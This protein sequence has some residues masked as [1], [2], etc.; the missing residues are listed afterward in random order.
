MIDRDPTPPAERKQIDG[1]WVVAAMLLGYFALV[2]VMAHFVGYKKAW[3]HVGVPG[4]QPVFADLRVITAAAD[5]DRDGYN[6]LVESPRDHWKRPMDY[7]RVWLLPLQAFNLGQ[8]ATAALGFALAAAF[9]ACV[10]WFMGRVSV[11]QGVLWGLLL[12]APSTM[13]AVERGNN[14]LV[15]F[16]LLALAVIFLRRKE[17]SAWVAYGLVGLCAVLK[18]YPICAFMLAWRETPRRTLT[19]FA[20]AALL[21]GGYLYGIRADLHTLR[22][23][24]PRARGVAYGARV[25]FDFIARHEEPMGTSSPMPVVAALAAISLAVLARLRI[26]GPAPLSRTE[27]DGLMVG[28]ALYVS[29]FVVNSN[30]NYRLIMLLL[31]VPALWRLSRSEA[32]FYRRLGGTLLGSMVVGWFLSQLPIGEAFFTKEAANWIVFVGMTFLLGQ[33]LPLPSALGEARGVSVWRREGGQNPVELAEN[34]G[35]GG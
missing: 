32:L 15:I 20:V 7:P 1:R 12:C 33:F 14:D 4:L 22:T 2:G 17:A 34:F 31:A 13:M 18:L 6:A 8:E 27:A 3:T 5:S 29:T 11:G 21:F 9:F 26:P 35:T 25:Y 19:I 28:G 23:T 24:V 16:V 10:F 30:F